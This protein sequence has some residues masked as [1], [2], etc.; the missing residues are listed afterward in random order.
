MTVIVRA[1]V[2]P[3]PSQTECVQNYEKKTEHCF[4]SKNPLA[5][6]KSNGGPAPKNF[7]MR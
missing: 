4:S 2:I 7:L 6:M 5:V 1:F 3:A